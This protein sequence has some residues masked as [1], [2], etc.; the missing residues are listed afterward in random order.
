MK[1]VLYTL[2]MLAT[3]IL[4]GGRSEQL[5]AQCEEGQS[6]VVV[7]ILTDN[8]PGEITW[9]LSDVNGSLLTGGPY[10]DSGTSYA[11]TICISGAD[12]FP[13][14]Q[15]VINDSYGDGICCGYGQGAYTLYLDGVAVA[16]GG[17]YGQQDQ[18]Q[19]DCAPGATCNDAVTLTDA[20]YGTLT[21][22]EDNF[23]Y[24]FTPAA[25]GMYEFSSCGA[26]CNTTLY[27]YE[28]CNMG[29]FDD[30]RPSTTTTTKAAVERKRR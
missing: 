10:N 17:D 16:T 30:P 2:P 19:F 28:Y 15:F 11:D 22:A 14:L 1:H 27:I 3:L 12:E 13:C 24:V 6:Q 20:D 25:N 7:E 29:N 18:V 26:G 21:Q 23:W 8:Y 4:V 9:T 5:I